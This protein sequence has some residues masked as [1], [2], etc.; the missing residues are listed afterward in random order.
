[1]FKD[2]AAAA[3]GIRTRT[4][5][6]V[7][8]VSHVVWHLV[9]DPPAPSLTARSLTVGKAIMDEPPSGPIVQLLL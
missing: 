9:Q 5:I 1:M 3:G 4:R 7:W 2:H 6:A 8:R